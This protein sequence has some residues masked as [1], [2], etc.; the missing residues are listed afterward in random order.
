MYLYAYFLKCFSSPI[1]CFPCYFW[2]CLHISVPNMTGSVIFRMW[3]RVA[4][5]VARERRVSAA[6]QLASSSFITRYRRQSFSLT[7]LC[8]SFALLPYFFSFLS[9]PLRP[10]R[11]G[12]NRFSLSFSVSPLLS[13]RFTTNSRPNSSRGMERNLISEIRYNRE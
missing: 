10:F 13:S 3:W 7:S 5:L 8:T 4:F 9:L 12:L 11:S 2:R 6:P 1:S